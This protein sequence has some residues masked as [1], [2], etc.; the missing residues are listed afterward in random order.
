[1]TEEEYKNLKVD[2]VLVYT[3]EDSWA[4]KGTRLK[5]NKIESGQIRVEAIDNGKINYDP[6]IANLDNGYPVAKSYI[7]G[8][9]IIHKEPPK[10]YKHK[11]R[12]AL[13]TE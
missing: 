5:I 2:D 9:F 6:R 4:A 10:E 12:L 3:Y 11:S 7:L 8:Q 1:M 13:I